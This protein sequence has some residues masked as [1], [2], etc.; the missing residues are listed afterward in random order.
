ME[1][2]KECKNAGTKLRLFVL[3]GRLP[4]KHQCLML[5]A[6][7]DS[8]INGETKTYVVRD[9]LLSKEGGGP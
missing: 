7:P 4:P 1:V 5:T 3:K 2:W 9:I 6:P 8:I